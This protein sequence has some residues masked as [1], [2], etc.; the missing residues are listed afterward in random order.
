MKE[1]FEKMTIEELVENIATGKDCVKQLEELKRIT[2][3]DIEYMQKRLS[4][5]STKEN[6]ERYSNI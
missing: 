3:E 1:Q 6:N 4:F 2:E 5:L